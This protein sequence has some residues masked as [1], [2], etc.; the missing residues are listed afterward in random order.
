MTVPSQE[1]H[2]A[3][4]RILLAID[5]GSDKCGIAVVQGDGMVTLH[6]VVPTSDIM[7][8][9]KGLQEHQTFDAVILG[10]GTRSRELADQLKAQGICTNIEFVD[11]TNST[12]EARNRYFQDNPPRG[13]R[14][15]LPRG[16]LT[17]VEPYDDYA[18]IILAERYLSQGT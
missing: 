2:S 18:A 17:P 9:L 3:C 8:F 5:P 4:N 6:Q 12:L 1:T 13:L 10:N 15:F 7:D 16:M 14:R 11:E